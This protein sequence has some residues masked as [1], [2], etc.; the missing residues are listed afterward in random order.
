MLHLRRAL[1]LHPLLHPCLVPQLR[2]A[3]Q[4]SHVPRAA[5]NAA[6]AAVMHCILSMHHVPC[7]HRFLSGWSSNAYRPHALRLRRHLLPYP[8][9]MGQPKVVHCLISLH[10]CVAYIGH[11]T[12]RSM[13]INV[14][15]QSARMLG[16]HCPCFATSHTCRYSATT[17]VRPCTATHHMCLNVAVCAVAGSAPCIACST[18]VASHACNHGPF[19]VMFR[20]AGCAVS[21]VFT[22]VCHP[23]RITVHMHDIRHS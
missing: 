21:H 15:L 1:Q 8:L 5:V 13:C 17:S 7:L 11:A 10:E 3:P 20:C 6:L 2:H 18:I 22:R 14:S 23:R 19:C 4:L 9:C 12:T 16:N